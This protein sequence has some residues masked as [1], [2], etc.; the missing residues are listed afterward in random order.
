MF[1][2]QPTHKLDPQSD[3]RQF[4]HRQEVARSFFVSGCDT[5]EGGFQPAKEALDFI[6][7]VVN[8]HLLFA[9]K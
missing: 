2:R 5:A 8:P 6:A 1:S 3:R 9:G 4:D 7:F